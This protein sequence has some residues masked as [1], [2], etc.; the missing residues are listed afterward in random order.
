MIL[1]VLLLNK[2]QLTTFL[3]AFLV[4]TVKP[5]QTHLFLLDFPEVKRTLNGNYKEQTMVMV[6]V[7]LTNQTLTNY[8]ISA[9]TV[10]K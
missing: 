9:M 6:N 3:W 4:V 10:D 2:R 1:G 5:D 8:K 7:A